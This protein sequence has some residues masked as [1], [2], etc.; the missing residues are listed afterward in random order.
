MVDN[1]TDV[2]TEPQDGWVMEL[3]LI[4]NDSSLGINGQIVKSAM[5]QLLAVPEFNYIETFRIMTA[6]ARFVPLPTR[7]SPYEPLPSADPVRQKF[8]V[9]IAGFL[10][11]LRQFKEHAVQYDDWMEKAVRN[12]AVREVVNDV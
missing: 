11:S 9:W 5:V 7:G 2:T 6:L 10:E 4:C 3:R 1:L 8:N 12:A